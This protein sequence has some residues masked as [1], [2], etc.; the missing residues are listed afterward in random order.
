MSI[1]RYLRRRQWDEERASEMEAHLAHEIDDNL[2]RGLSPEEARRRAYLHLGNPTRIREEIWTMN[3]FSGFENLAR[4]FRYA[5]RQLLRSPGFAVIAVLTLALGIGAAAA[6]FSV[7]DAVV[8]APLPYRNTGRIVRIDTEAAAKYSQPESWPELQDM[9]RLNKTFSQIVGVGYGG[10][11]TLRTADRAVYLHAVQGTANF[12]ILFGV[13]PILG[14]TYL[15]G[16]DQIGKNH[17]VVLSY[18]AWQQY[19]GGDKSAVG[20]VVDLNGS[21][22][23]IIG[24][25]PAGF[26][27]LFDASNVVYTPLQ[28][29]A[30]QIK[31][32]GSHW[33]PAWGLLRPGVTLTQAT[34][35]I[36]HVFAE[37]GTQ[38][39]AEEKGKTANVVSIQQSLHTNDFGT[40]DRTEIWILLA[41]VASVLLIACTNVAGLLM[42]RGLRREREMA[43]R[44]ALGAGHK[45]LIGQMLT[46]SV[47]LGL[48]GGL[49]GVVLGYLLLIAMRQFL[50]KAFAR[51]GDVQLN[52][53]VVAAT[54]AVAL[55]ASIAAG[56][57]P[58]WRSARPQAAQALKTGLSAGTSRR[59]HRLRSGFVIV[60]VAL[61]LILLVCSGLLL[62]GLRS[63][64]Q[65]NL[66][67]NPH[68]LLTLEVDIPAG[69]YKTRD[70]VTALVQPLEARVAAIP[71]VT[72]VGSNDLLPILQY[73]SN[74][75][76][77]LVGHA[78]DPI[79]HERLTEMRFVTPGYFAAM[80]LPIL[81]GRD[82]SAEDTAKSQPVAVVNEAWVKEFLKPGEDPLI[83]AFASDPPAPPTRIVG[84]A[85]SGRQN[86][87]QHPLAE[88]DFPFS[89]M[90]ADW[91]AFVPQ[92]Y[93]FIRTSV[94]PT[95]ITPQLRRALR[96]VAP[97]VAFRT[98]ET[99]QSVLNDALVTNRMLSW[100]FG[101]FAAIAALLTAIGIYGLLSQEVA[102]RTRDIGV[103]MALGATRAG[104]ARLILIRTCILLGSGLA[105]GLVGVFL[106]HRLILSMLPSHTATNFGAIAATAL[107]MA[108]IG[109][110]AAAI[111]ARRAT[112]ID[113]MRALRIE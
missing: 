58:A 51:G 41:A 69:D 47:V 59:Q 104:V 38:F 83:Q 4:D 66:G 109:L 86:I 90:P 61:S 27:F 60:Q 53:V 84:V 110:V 92:F 89:Q 40:D 21:P 29:T 55:F 30:D 49:C 88:A 9:R 102:S 50:E 23:T 26:R 42:A 14:R 111:P 82:L 28:L 77:S 3:S 24:V 2:A 44:A 63:M 36:N 6:M 93:L 13:S 10:G 19:F 18:G 99:M 57:V 85:A 8:L 91:M 1:R 45:R 20:R 48:A 16:E 65:T 106:V 100:L 108:A 80:Q 70:F 76:I 103:R 98:P 97:N 71:G 32:R 22:F 95:S 96:D 54:V 11:V 73:G 15:P 46:Q 87:M 37:L 72:A 52:L 56:L 7:I 35:D 31:S 78:P 101:L 12:F 107:L 5:C 67:F 62:L 34:A 33:L 43:L 74:S 64:L 81:Q 112:R 75:D 79:D 25:M 68:H 113:P 39:P 105:A 94:P 17:V